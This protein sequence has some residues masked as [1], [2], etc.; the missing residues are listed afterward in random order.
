MQ[1][2][3][4]S[5]GPTIPSFDFEQG[6]NPAIK[7]VRQALGDIAELAKPRHVT[8][9]SSKGNTPADYAVTSR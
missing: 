8:A 7:T 9:N 3:S 6:I 4:E 5:S 1:K 2:S